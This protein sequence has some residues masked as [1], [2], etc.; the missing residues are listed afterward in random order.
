MADNKKKVIVYTDWIDTFENLSDEEAGQLIKHFFRYV[1]DLNPETDNRIVN[2]M[3]IPIKATLKR[4]LI[5]WESKQEK[6][7]ENGKLGGRPPKPKETQ[8]N[9]T[10]ISETQHNPEKGVI[11]SVSDTVSV[12]DNDILL[13]KETKDIKEK[14]K[15]F[16]P[17]SVNEVKDYCIERK[18]TVDAEGWM[19]HYT[20][21]GWMVGKNKMK[22][23]RAAV[24]TWEKNNYGNNGKSNQNNQYTPRTGADKLADAKARILEYNRKLD[25]SQGMGSVEDADYTDVR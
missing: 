8:I 17:P 24:R 22:D 5:A 15:R 2:L 9:P 13:E 18:N 16:I 10:V 3:F 6:N 4:D 1:N 12:N 7:R 14:P 20:A 19:N 11:V 21:N 23:W 25:E